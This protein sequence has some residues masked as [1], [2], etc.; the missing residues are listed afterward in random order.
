MHIRRNIMALLALLAVI[1]Y[2]ILIAQPS[3]PRLPNLLVLQAQNQPTILATTT[4]LLGSTVNT[5]HPAPPT[6]AE[7]AYLLDA[8][9]GAVLYSK[10][11]SERLP[12]YSTTKLMTALIAVSH[13]SLDQRILIDAKIENDFHS[14]LS[15]D[16][17]LMGLQAGET[18][19]LRELL[20]G[21]LLLSG[22]DAAVAIAD[23]ISGS[24]PSFVGLMNQKAVEIGMDDTNFTN[25]HGLFYPSHYSSAH[26]LALLGRASL[27]VASIAQISATREWKLAATSDHHG[28]DMLNGNQFLWWYPGAN[29]G[30]PGY[31][32]E[33]DF[34]Q[35]ISV[36]RNNRRLIGVALNTRDW[37]TDMRDLM[38][39]G[40]DNFQWV[41][42]ADAVKHQFIP[43]AAEWNNF[44]GDNQEKTIPINDGSYFIYTGYSISGSIQHYF[45]AHGGLQTFGYPTSMPQ[46]TSGTTISQHF[47]HRTIFCNSQTQQ[48]YM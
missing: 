44:S 33:K 25:P 30:K 39:F 7:A 29:G 46:S 47:E 45:D 1:G 21:L 43:Y 26:D 6:Y 35:I 40:F 18:Y 8:N 24:I 22:N 20:Y 34:N 11:S 41:S 42:P 28:Y 14:W 5:K 13:G 31:D 4:P 2:T 3:P 19:T 16:S 12:M 15:S 23:G 32:G 10:N 48:C 17:S 36:V 37:W 9:T 38:N 27:S